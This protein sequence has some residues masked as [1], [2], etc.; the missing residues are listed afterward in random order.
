MRRLRR[1]VALLAIAIGGVLAACGV[2]GAPEGTVHLARTDGTVGPIMERYLDRAIDRAEKT[3]ARLLVIELDTP[4]GLVSSMRKIVNR[5]QRADVPVAVYV[6]PTGARA[7]SAGTFITMAGHIAAMAPATSIGAASAIN[8]DGSDI[9]GALGRKIEEDA[10]A[11]IRGI[12]E[13]RGR[14]A[15]WAEDAVRK[16]VAVTSSRAVE[17]NVVDFIANDIE[18]LLAKAEGRTVELRPGVTVTLSGLRDAAI[19]RTDMTVWEHF[20]AFLADPTIASLLISIGFLAILAEVFNPGLIIPGLGGA[21][22]MVLG[23]A[24]FGI[25]PVDTVGLV[26]IAA[27]LALLAAEFFVPGGILGGVGAVA[28]VLGAVIAFRDTPAEFRPPTWLLVTLGVVIIGMLLSAAFTVAKSRRLFSRSV[29]TEAMIGGTAI[30]RTPL[31]PEGFVLYQGERWK[32]RLEDDGEAYPGESLR[33]TGA[34]GLRLRVRK[35]GPR[36]QSGT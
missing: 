26:L 21:I 3:D 4:G 2:Q 30:V 28:L 22:A 35:E 36:D 13:Q 14:N 18:D 16:A 20:L 6:G 11:F 12:A 5:I 27:G 15:D 19:T 34:D 23:F 7:A 9:E 31:T 25:L 17:L 8:A 24:G 32:A 33:I 29:G 1:T 10:V